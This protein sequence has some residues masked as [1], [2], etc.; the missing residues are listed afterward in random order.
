VPNS[1]FLYR[2][3]ATEYGAYWYHAHHRGSLEDGLFGPIYITPAPTVQK[4]FGLIANGSAQL[5]AMINAESTTSQVIL[6]D[7]RSLTSEQIWAAE[8]ASG[9]DAWCANAL[10]INGK[11]SVTCLPQDQI[12]A[13]TT[14]AQRSILG[15][16]RNLTDMA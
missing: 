5:N 6:S 4:P 10:L 9:T 15:P 8:I 12:N 14:P 2:W 13:L 3:K 11:G 1:S 16:N 7:W